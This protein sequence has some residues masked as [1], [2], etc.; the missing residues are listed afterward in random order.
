MLTTLERDIE[1]AKKADI[2]AAH[3][4]QKTEQAKE[5]EERAKETKMF[6]EHVR[7]CFATFIQ[8]TDAKVDV[9]GRSLEFKYKRKTYRVSLDREFR[10]ASNCGEGDG[11]HKTY[12][13]HGWPTQWPCQRIADFYNETTRHIPHK[14]GCGCGCLGRG[15]NVP[16]DLYPK[17]VRA[18]CEAERSHHQ[19]GAGK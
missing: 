15:V 13:L 1:R 17:I 12:M 10:T 14:A 16:V 8:K 19:I 7:G 6:N 9:L 3:R 2:K 5:R 18:Y 11:Y 4:E